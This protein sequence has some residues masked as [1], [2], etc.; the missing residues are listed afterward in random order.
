MSKFTLINKRSWLYFLLLGFGIISP[1]GWAQQTLNVSGKV[2]SA[3][4]NMPIPGVSILV[5]GTTTGTT[6]DFDGN[7][8][9]NVA[10]DATLSFSYVGFNTQ[11]VL[12]NGQT[13]INISLQTN[14]SELEEVVVVGY[15]TQRRAL[16][17]GANLQVDGDELQNQSLDHIPRI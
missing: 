4:D 11:E 17:T 13:T 16:V 15:G 1:T 9:I 14:T 7:Y 2:T 3:D 6:T 8:E 12:V 10:Q 5:L